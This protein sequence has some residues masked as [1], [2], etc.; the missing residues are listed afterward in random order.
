MRYVRCER[1]AR[2][3]DARRTPPTDGSIQIECDNLDELIADFDK[4][5]GPAN[6]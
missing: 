3:S 5:N 2:Q 4:V 6:P 1:Y